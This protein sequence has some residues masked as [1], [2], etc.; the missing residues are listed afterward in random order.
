MGDSMPKHA[1]PIHCG[2]GSEH[3][4]VEVCQSNLGLDPALAGIARPM[5]R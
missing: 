5:E 2:I 1:R 3:A 4:L